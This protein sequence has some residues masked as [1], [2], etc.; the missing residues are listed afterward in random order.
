MQNITSKGGT[1]KRP[2][3]YDPGRHQF[4]QAYCSVIRKQVLSKS[5]LR[6]G[7]GRICNSQILYNPRMKYEWHQ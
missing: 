3:K 2:P 6:E 7:S 5:A 1:G 4:H